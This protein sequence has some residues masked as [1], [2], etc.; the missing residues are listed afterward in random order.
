M[1]VT[2]YIP[3]SLAGAL[4]GEYRFRQRDGSNN[5]DRFSF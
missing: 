1:K 2:K 4:A 3:Y 5:A